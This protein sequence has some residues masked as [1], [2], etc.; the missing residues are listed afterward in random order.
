MRKFTA[1]LAGGV[2]GVP[3]KATEF[4]FCNK[5]R[6]AAGA[7]PD[8]ESIVSDTSV[9]FVAEIRFVTLTFKNTIRFSVIV[10]PGLPPEQLRRISPRISATPSAR[11][12]G[13]T[14]PVAHVSGAW[15]WAMPASK[16]TRAQK[17]K[18]RIN[19]GI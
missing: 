3:F 2:E 11:T 15:G 13:F 8:P 6:T 18:A 4:I 9:A 7:G 1:R 17:R 16:T 10:V 12:A 5:A 14:A 19:M